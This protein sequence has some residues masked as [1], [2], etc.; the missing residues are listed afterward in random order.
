MN[1]DLAIIILNI[2]GQFPP[3]KDAKWPNGSEQGSS[4]CC[5]QNAYLKFK[6][7]YY[8]RV[9]RLKS[10]LQA[11]ETRKQASIA[12]PISDKIDVLFI[13]FIF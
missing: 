1:I 4:F 6:E 2:N 9:K 7:S 13:Y 12:I 5:L 11:I 3:S 10:I 8:L